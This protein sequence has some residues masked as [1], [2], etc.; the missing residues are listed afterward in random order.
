MEG[1]YTV[2]V[3]NPANGCTAS[4]TAIVSKDAATP[5]VVATGGQLTCEVT[6][7]PITA[8]GSPQNVTYA[9]SGPSN[10]TAAT[11]SI[12]ATLEGI[13]TVTVTNPANGCT[14]SDT[15]IV[16]KDAATPTVVATGGQLTCEVTSLPITATGSPQTITY[17][18]NGP[19]NFTA[20]TASITAT[21]EGIYTVTV[22]NPA[23]GCS[24]SDTAIV[25]ISTKK[26]SVGINK[27]LNLACIG[28]IP[29]I[30][31]VL[32]AV[33][34]PNASWSQ[35]GNQSSVVSFA[36]AAD[37]N[38]TV[39]GLVPGSYT[40]VW[41][42]GE[43]A[44][45][46][47]V[48]VPDC[49]EECI[50]PEAGP[51]LSICAPVTTADLPN[52][53][54]NQ[55]W[56]SS[57]MNPAS[58]SIDSQSG[59]VRGMTESGVFIFYLNDNTIGS[60]CS[61]TVF[62]F[63]GIPNAP[64]NQSTCTDTLTLPVVAGSSYAVAALNPAPATI[65]SSGSIQG[66]SAIGVYTFIL[67]NG[68]CIDT[69]LV[70]KLNCN[71]IYDLALDKSISKKVA[72]LGDTLTY[73]IRVWNEGEAIAHGIE[74]TDTLNAGVQYLSYTS[75]VGNYSNGKW[76]F[77][78]IEVGD[79][80]SLNIKVRVIGLGVWFNTA[81]ITKMT[82]KDEDSTPNNGDES[83]DDIDREC[84]TVPIEVCRGQ[85]Y[86]ASVPN[87]YT[88]VVWFRDDVQVAV[89][90]SLI[91]SESGQYTFT[92]TETQCPAQGCCP[93]MVA[94]IDCCPVDVCVPFVIKK[95]RSGK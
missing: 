49:N 94:V 59:I 4:D 26:P 28:S 76:T 67:S 1:I 22:T 57:P 95:T 32:N 62:I 92:A 81:E 83:E 45:T 35:V 43:C 73:T 25:S 87:Q 93:I 39:S 37:P 53:G 30:S 42:A 34:F 3:T 56:V 90:N 19:S 68:T 9:W 48:L 33:P 86:V 24:A 88:N 89:G 15:A 17:A 75:T 71:K 70:E 64:T 11:A 72:Q 50:K 61:D 13:Y 55:S 18:W 7:L 41:K 27:Q 10:F 21:L 38:T 79:T 65:T 84:F 77:D 16:S 23:N 5:T 66:M 51:D 6:S 60:T 69:V 46:L 20:T 36:N 78:S 31:T 82:E 54:I 29:V 44:D 80:L 58:I 12:T 91:I 74:V 63:R 85:A 14:A 52:A 47:R 40:F 8:T 2:T